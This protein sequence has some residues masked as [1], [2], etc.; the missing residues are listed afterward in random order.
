VVHKAFIDVNEKGTEAG[1]GT[2]VKGTGA[3]VGTSKP[4]V[5]RADHPFLFMIRDNQ[6][7]DVI[8]FLGRFAR[9][10]P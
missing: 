7:A 6:A 2:G 5:F 1:A 3:G 4:V 8:L 9:P 10:E